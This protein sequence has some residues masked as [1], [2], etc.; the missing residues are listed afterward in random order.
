MKQ[1]TKTNAANIQNESSV[2]FGPSDEDS[3]EN[4]INWI[5]NWSLNHT[6]KDINLLISLYQ[7]SLP[8]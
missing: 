3:K 4:K 1:N 2:T 7:S 5:L 6:D 8:R